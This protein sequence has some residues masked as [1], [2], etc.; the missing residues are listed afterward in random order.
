MS[1]DNMRRDKEMLA[2]LRR[3]EGQI[4]GLQRMIEEGRGCA[5][6]IQQLS[7]AKRALDQVGLMI[8]ANRM[9]ECLA[10]APA[11]EPTLSSD[12]EDAM[13]LLQKLG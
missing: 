3:I 8:V 7:A 13:K 1:E 5:E 11:H 10:A 12:V 4:R 6:F 2:R 9:A